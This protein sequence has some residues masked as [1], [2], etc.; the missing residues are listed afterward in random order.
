MKKLPKENLK[1]V[2][3]AKATEG[4]SAGNVCKGKISSSNALEKNISE[5]KIA[6]G[7]QGIARG[8][9]EDAL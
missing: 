7:K 2:S 9:S 5:K 8:I 4:I 1:K 6:G 3:G